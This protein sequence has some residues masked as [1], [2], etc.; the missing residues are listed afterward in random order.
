MLDKNRI[1]NLKNISHETLN[2][3]I[4][5]KDDNYIG[6]LN[7]LNKNNENFDLVIQYLTQ[8]RSN[9][10]KYFLTQF[11][12]TFERTKSWLEEVVFPSDSKLLFIIFDDHDNLI[13]NI[14]VTN[15]SSNSC[16][17]D[18]LIRGEQ[19]GHP[20]LIYYTEVCLIRWLFLQN[21]LYNVY[22]HVFS[23]NYL[24]IMLHKSVGFNEVNR[25]DLFKQISE[26]G[27]IQYL[28][29]SDEMPIN[30]KSTPEYIKMRLDYPK[31]KSIHVKTN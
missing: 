27:E 3:N 13:G 26:N 30:I 7:L 15:I 31:F 11:N 9:N 4:L 5:D 8:W 6:R 14:G 1:V 12:A 18:N 2:I 10:M 17:I 25:Y 28:K 19:G 16:E 22:L 20:S 23:N 21:P 24:T 29:Q